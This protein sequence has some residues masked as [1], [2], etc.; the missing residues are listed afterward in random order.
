M[1]NQNQNSVY[2]AIAMDAINGNNHFL[3]FSKP[4]RNTALAF[5]GNNNNF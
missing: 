2:P 4:L 5:K 3:F 1:N